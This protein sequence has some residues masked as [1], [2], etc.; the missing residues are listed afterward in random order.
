MPGAKHWKSAWAKTLQISKISPSV[1]VSHSVA[2][3]FPWASVTSFS[4]GVTPCTRM[5]TTTVM[6]FRMTEMTEKKARVED[7][8]H[9]TRAAVESGIVPGGGVA[10]I[11]A[12]KALDGI[13]K[14]LNQEQVAGVNIVR[15]AIEAPLHRIAENAGVEGSVVVVTG[16]E[17]VVV[18]GSS[19]APSLVPQAAATR[20]R[21]RTNTTMCR[22]CLLMTF[23][24]LSLAG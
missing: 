14:G 5:M 19:P 15:R 12:Q 18:V 6:I 11:R 13:E 17:V 2:I 20:P 22:G 9:A 3:S 23:P 4:V 8:L 24:S 7:A 21:A 10:L 16:A 1:A